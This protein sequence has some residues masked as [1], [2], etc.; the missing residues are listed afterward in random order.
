MLFD[1]EVSPSNRVSRRDETRIEPIG[2]EQVAFSS[3][4]EG[5]SRW[6]A[7]YEGKA[8]TGASGVLKFW[9]F[10]MK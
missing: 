3:N 4:S 2:V 6:M 9:H 5:Q 1:L 10:D 8:G 7:T